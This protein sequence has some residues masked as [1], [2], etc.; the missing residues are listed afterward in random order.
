MFAL[1]FDAVFRKKLIENIK[2]RITHP[3]FSYK[4]EEKLYELAKFIK[5]HMNS[6]DASGKG[7]E[8]DSLKY[9][10]MEYVLLEDLKHQISFMSPRAI[11]YYQNNFSLD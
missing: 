6:D 7:N 11:D 5:K 3:D 10:L 2:G 4:S 8:F 1:Y 9:V